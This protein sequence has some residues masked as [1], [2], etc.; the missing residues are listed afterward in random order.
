MPS[1]G[2]G[3]TVP[4]LRRRRDEARGDEEKRAAGRLWAQVFG[5]QVEQPG[6]HELLKELRALVDEYGDRVLVGESE[7][8]DF[9][10]DGNDELHLLF[11]FPLMQ[12]KR[13]T[14]ATI[15]ANQEE[16]LSALPAGAWP[17]NTLGNHD[18]PR[19]FNRYGDG[20][21]D[22]ALARLS[23]ALVLTL[24][25]TPFLYYGEEIGMTDLRLDNIHQFRDM[26]GVW[27]YQALQDERGLSPEAALQA[28]SELTRD[29]CRTP[30]QWGGGANGGFCP[31]TIEPWLPVHPNHT[32][33]VN[34]ADQLESPHS[35]LTFYRT[36]LGV[37][38][39][40]PALIWGD[41]SPLQPNDPDLL[42]F[43]RTSEEQRCLV[44]LNFSASART[45]AAD[46]R[47]P[48]TGDVLYGSHRA[49]EEEITLPETRIAP[50]E[51]LLCDV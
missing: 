42:L 41:Y 6:I 5:A 47:T 46:S 11:N 34:V 13:L 28:A 4:E 29:K 37:R 15:R 17:C 22:D 51:I 12:P 20:E 23:L 27:F 26:L 21:N 14:A 49:A 48:T 40:N 19:V 9:Y 30:M 1:H 18:S 7:R 2:T 10:G 36:L 16:R 33:G 32:A 50:F 25:G 43:T 45:I 38:R 8:V 35:L 44:A 3:L 39:E 24:R 31:A